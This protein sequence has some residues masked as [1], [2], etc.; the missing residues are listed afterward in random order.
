MSEKYNGW[1]NY[2]TWLCKLWMDNDQ[3]VDEFMGELAQ[4]KWDD[5]EPNSYSTRSQAARHEMRLSLEEWIPV[6]MVPEYDEMTGFAAD[7]VQAALSTVDYREIADSIL[8][9]VEG[10][11]PRKVAA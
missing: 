10:Y 3:G 1:Q 11:E 5:A 6:N 4:E 9:E 8:S 7:L 2:E